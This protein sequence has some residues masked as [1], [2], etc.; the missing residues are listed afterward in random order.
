MKD[1]SFFLLEDLNFMV[2]PVGA[3]LMFTLAAPHLTRGE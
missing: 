2:G 1:D 3:A